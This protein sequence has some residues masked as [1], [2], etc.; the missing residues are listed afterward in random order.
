MVLVSALLEPG[1]AQDLFTQGLAQTG[2]L[3]GRTPMDHRQLANRPVYTCV[4][5][6]YCP[7]YRDPATILQ[8]S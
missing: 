4:A 5:Q 3:A 2:D 1:S 7:G 8:L 6:L